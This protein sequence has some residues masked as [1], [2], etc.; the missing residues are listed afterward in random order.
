[1]LLT[2]LRN[3]RVNVASRGARRAAFTLLEVLIVVAILV[4]LASAASFA[5]FRYLE[6]AKIGRAK[7]DMKAIKTA[8]DSYYIENGYFPEPDQIMVIA[9]KL[10][11]GEAGLMDPWGRPYQFE[12]V[13]VQASDGTA[14]RRVLVKCQPPDQNKPEITVPDRNTGR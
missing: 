8:L 3:T 5:Y 12:I 14:T 2:T 1:M 4:I 13:D 10:E 6:D 11:Q 7:A 9:P